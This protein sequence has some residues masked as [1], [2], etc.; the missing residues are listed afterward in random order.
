MISNVSYLAGLGKSD[1]LVICF[2]FICYTQQPETT[3]NKLNDFKG[4]YLEINKELEAIDWTS[5]LQGLN[6]T[7]LWETLA[8]KIIQLVEVNI[9]VCGATLGAV[10]KCPYANHQCLQAIKQKHSKWSKY[11]HCKSDRNYEEY[12]TARIRVI[13][14]LTKAKY[15]H[16]KDLA[17]KIKTNSK[18]FSGYV[19]SKLKTKSAIG[20]LEASDG[21]AIN[22]NQE[23]ANLLHNYFASVFQKEESMPLPNFDDRQFLQELNT[24]LVTEENILK[25]IDRIKPTK[26]QG[27][28]FI[29][30]KLIKDCKNALVTPLKKLFE[31]SIPEAKV[32]EIWKTTHVTAIFKSGSKSRPRTIDQ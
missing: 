5:I 2:Q 7:E 21:S 10:K 25:A 13:S 24:I 30:P 29:H 32:P 14:E 1:H 28:D 3:V 16:E 17:A 26:S 31:K 19:R 11:Q 12:K 22:G 20:Q 9:P 23:R 27:P 8:D 18:L 4:N 15:Y 6:L